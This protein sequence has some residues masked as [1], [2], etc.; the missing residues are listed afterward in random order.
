MTD[1]Q[2]VWYQSPDGVSLY[3]R[4]YGSQDALLAPLICLPG[5]T[6]NSKEFHDLARLISGERRII[7]ADYRGR[8]RSHHAD[9]QTYQVPVEMADVIALM[10]HLSIARAIFVGTSRGGL[11]SMLMATLH[12]DRMA[13]VVLNDIGPV[14]EPAGLARISAY[15]GKDP[16]LESWDAAAAALRATYRG[17]RMSEA[18]WARF[19]RVIFAEHEGLPVLDYDPD[20]ARTLPDEEM[21][22]S[23]PLPDFWAGF[24]ALSGLPVAAIRGEASDVLS[25][26]TLRQ[27]VERL[28][29]LAAV[30]VPGRGHTP[31][32]TE[33][34][35]LAAIRQVLAAAD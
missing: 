23:G 20:L 8:G 35:A 29:G 14:I 25:A 32:L 30:T 7:A 15:V 9:W 16:E 26:D 12:K 5:L 13:G 33:S 31:F 19:A 17:F 27:M 22:A 6:R 4:D 34:A 24:E 2:D 3:A 10:D 28:P 11:I 21:L 1:W 18:E